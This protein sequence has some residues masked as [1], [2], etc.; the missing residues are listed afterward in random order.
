MTPIRG[1]TIS[2]NYGPLLS[3]TLPR[4]LRHLAS[5][6][7]VTSPDDE[8]TQ[9]VARSLPGVRPVVT[10]AATRHGACFNKGLMFEEAWDA[11]GRDG[12]WLIWD[13]DCLFHEEMDLSACQTGRLYGA[14][15]RIL[16]DPSRW[17]PDLDWR[18]CPYSRDGGPIGYFQLFH[19]DDPAIKDKRP[20]YDVS[21]AHAG[22]G[23][24]Y[25]MGHWTNDKRCVLPI[26]VLHLGPKDTHWFGTDPAA[27]K[28]MEAF[29]VR[30]GWHRSHPRVDLKAPEKVGEIVERV[31]VPGYEKSTFELPFVRRAQQMRGK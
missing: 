9:A 25:F 7:V 29:I 8:H 18:A 20:W 6:V 2:V 16:E 28:V 5:C 19:G 3:I 22:G 21:F 10:D 26:D 15:R 27:K 23:D 31:D 13:A 1:I 12:W 17:T 30:N 11:V 14:R 4:N 24:A